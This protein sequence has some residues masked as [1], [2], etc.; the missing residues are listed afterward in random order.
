MLP[1]FLGKKFC[2][3]DYSA[4]FAARA[5]NP[6]AKRSSSIKLYPNQPNYVASS[7]AYTRFRLECRAAEN[8][9]TRDS[10]IRI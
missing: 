9:G 10:M 4:T 7:R 2:A 1:D 3:V 5:Q 6:V 8:T